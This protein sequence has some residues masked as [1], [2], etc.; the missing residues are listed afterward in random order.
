MDPVSLVISTSETPADVPGA[1][2]TATAGRGAVAPR[3]RGVER[4]R[5]RGGAARGGGRVGRVDAV[6]ERRHVRGDWGAGGDDADRVVAVGVVREDPVVVD[7]TVGQRAF[8]AARR[9]RGDH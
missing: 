3:G 1:T 7:R 6:A 2:V 5:Q 4:T 9:R 8:N